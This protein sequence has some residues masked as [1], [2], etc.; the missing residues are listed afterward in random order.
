[1]KTT[2]KL[3]K[4]LKYL[5]EKFPLTHG[6]MESKRQRKEGR[7][8]A[9]WETRGRTTRPPESAKHY[10]L[11]NAAFAHSL[12]TLV[13]TGTY[14]GD[15]LYALRDDFTSLHS[16]ELSKDYY[17]LSQS[18]LQQYPHIKIHFGDSA[19]MLAKVIS[20]LNDK[21]TLFWLDAHYG[22]YRD[23]GAAHGIEY[24]PIIHELTAILKGGKN[25][26]YNIIIDD[27]RLFE[28]DPHYPR[29]TDVVKHLHQNGYDVKIEHD[30]AFDCYRM[31]KPL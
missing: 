5:L 27:A 8:L 25:S 7:R 1:M 18:R 29:M 2:I 16:I 11:R 23:E 15:T 9:E 31:N 26:S 17:A 30:A 13:E 28:N 10:N 6:V 21:P 24:A 20:Q 19:E 22:N 14:H 3:Q 12:T 4:Q